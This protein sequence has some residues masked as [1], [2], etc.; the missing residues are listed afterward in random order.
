MRIYSI[1][2][3]NKTQILDKLLY[4]F[5]NIKTAKIVSFKNESFNNSYYTV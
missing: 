5:N 1:L 3:K 2:F 4:T